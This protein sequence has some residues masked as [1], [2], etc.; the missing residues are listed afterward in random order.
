MHQPIGNCK[1]RPIV[2]MQAPIDL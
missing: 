1:P 2:G